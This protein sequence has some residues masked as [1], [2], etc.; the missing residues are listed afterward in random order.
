V[1]EE[2]EILISSEISGLRI[3]NDFVK[4]L[5][6]DE[7]KFLYGLM[8]I[9]NKNWNKINFR[10]DDYCKQIGVSK[11]QV[12]RKITSLTG[13]SPNEFI[14]EFRLR[15]ALRLIEKHNGNISEIAFESGFSNP[16]YFTQ[17]FRKRFGLLPS[18]FETYVT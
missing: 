5:K 12:Y 6:P 14:R 4:S 17:C 9:T 3:Y 8:E 2:G 18:E 11:S 7:E 15:K 13:R 16:S 10:V 1:A